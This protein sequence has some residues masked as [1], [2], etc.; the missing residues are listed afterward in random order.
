MYEKFLK[1]KKSE[2]RIFNLT[3]SL[4][5]LFLALGTYFVIKSHD[6]ADCRN[7]RSTLNMVLILHAVNSAETLLNLVGLEKKLCS[8]W[9]TCIF[10]FF[11]GIMV[12]YMQIV[13]F[14]SMADTKKNF[15]GCLELAPKLYLWMM[16]NILVFYLGLIVVICYF[17][18]GFFQ[19]PQLEEEERIKE[20][21][22]R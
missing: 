3:A 9:M 5:S 21:K 7:L 8:N 6:G 4:L 12:A 22:S 18:R 13:Y 15:R 20:L 10:L 2:W 19:D 16:A 14:N 17:F 11:E 1:E